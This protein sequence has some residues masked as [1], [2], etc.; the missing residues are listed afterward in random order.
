[1]S[2]SIGGARCDICGYDDGTHAMTCRHARGTR[3]RHEPSPYHQTRAWRIFNRNMES[4]APLCPN[5]KG[6]GYQGDGFYCDDCN[7]TGV[8]PNV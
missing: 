1:M 7:G 4:G 3:Q 5:C 8:K 2:S 6:S